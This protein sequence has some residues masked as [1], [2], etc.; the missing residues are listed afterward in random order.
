MPYITQKAREQIAAGAEPETAGEL[1]YCITRLILQYIEGE[2]LSYQNINDVL[3]ALTGAT[4]EFYCRIATPYEAA[5]RIANGDV[6][7]SAPAL[8][9]GR[10]DEQPSAM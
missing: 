10:P 7:G 8:V 5:K 4:H 9:S 3:G 2:A 6:Y 1:N